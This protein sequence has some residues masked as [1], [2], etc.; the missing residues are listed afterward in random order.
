MVMMEFT[1][2]HGCGND[3]VVVNAMDGSV[4]NP[5][6]LA[7]KIC[8]RRFGVGADGLILV[9][10]SDSADL[11]MQFINSDGSEAE[12]CG[13]GIRCFALFARDNQL[14]VGNKVRVETLAGILT[15]EIIDN[16]VKVDMGEPVLE[17]EMIPVDIQ[18]DKVVNEELSVN[19]QSFRMTCV[20]MGN[21]HCVIFVP[22][23]SDELVL[24]TG[25][26]IERHP[27]FPKKTNTEFVRVMNRRELEMRVFE[28]GAGETLACGTGACASAVAGVLNGHTDRE[29][30]VHLLGGDLLIQW[31]E[32]DN[33]VF[34]TGPAETVFKGTYNKEN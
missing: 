27:L 5:G 10:P 4:P 9:R 2:M 13:N 6:E 15:V 20:S 17:G 3:F 11:R 32:T 31:S 33:H 12:M 26:K 7:K 23:I 30:T 14:A 29:C 18:K 19:G 1:K 8:A 34:M 22:E 24:E 21:P 16:F 28:R 25:P